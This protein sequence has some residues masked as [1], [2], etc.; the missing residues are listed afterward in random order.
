MPTALAAPQPHYDVHHIKFLN[1]AMNGLDQGVVM[2]MTQLSGGWE[3]NEI[4]A[5]NWNFN[6]VTDIEIA[7]SQF[8][9]GSYGSAIHFVVTTGNMWVHN[10]Y[11]QNGITCIDFAEGHNIVVEYNICNGAT[12]NGFKFQPQRYTL[13]NLTVRG[14]LVY[15][16]TNFPFILYNARNSKIYNNTFAA[17]NADASSYESASIGW[18]VS[19]PAYFSGLGTWGLESNVFQNNIFYGWVRVST[20][21]NAKITYKGG[22]E[23][24]Y[25]YGTS[26]IM[27]NNDFKNNIFYSSFSTGRVRLVAQNSNAW[28]YYD[29]INCPSPGYCTVSDVTTGWIAS[30][31]D[32]ETKWNGT[33]PSITNNIPNNPVFVNFAGNDYHVQSSSPAIN[34]GIPIPE[35]SADLDGNPVVGTPTIGAY[36]Y[37]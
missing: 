11:I 25:T 37:P 10:N 6:D 34:S 20:A 7:N 16:T 35:W 27:Q 29:A 17:R 22:T 31:A 24:R 8:Y 3:A 30:L 14:N 13:D 12:G 36:Q 2:Q 9:D 32:F 21:N 26:S 5:E 19:N 15:G 33:Y 28:V 23:I 1:I 18:T 4:S